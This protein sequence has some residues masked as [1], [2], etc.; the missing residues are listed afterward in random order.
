[1]SLDEIVALNLRGLI[2]GQDRK[3]SVA[4]VAEHLGV[5]R[6]QVYDMLRPRP[7]RSHRE[8]KWSEIVKLA[9]LFDVLVFD[10]VL[11]PED[12]A[13]N[14]GMWLIGLTA[15]EVWE[16]PFETVSE[17]HVGALFR[18]EVA[19][20]LFGF[21]AGL[22]TRDTVA[23]L[24][25]LLRETKEERAKAVGGEMDELMRAMEELD[26]QAKKILEGLQGD[27]G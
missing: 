20:G 17:I 11:P 15:V 6:A 7:G 4:R 22:L 27:E 23:E 16:R 9:R 18:D 25:R 19:L 13:L 21:P 24:G 14:A 2:G 5:S 8:F 12:V 1:M 10:L 3:V 26:M